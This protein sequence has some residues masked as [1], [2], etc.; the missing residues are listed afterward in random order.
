MGCKWTSKEQ[1]T[2]LH[3]WSDRYRQAGEKKNYNSFWDKLFI[4][5]FVAFPKLAPP[6]QEVIAPE[7]WSKAQKD[8]MQKG[9]LRRKAQLKDWFWNHLHVECH[10]DVTASYVAKLMQD[11]EKG[12]GK[13]CKKL[14][15]VFSTQ[16]YQGSKAQTQE[17][18]RAKSSRHMKL[19]T[20]EITAAWKHTNKEQKEVVEATLHSLRECQELDDEGEALDNG[21]T[22]ENIQRLPL[23]MDAIMRDMQDKTGWCFSVLTEGCG[24]TGH[25]KTA[26]YHLGKM[27]N[28]NTFAKAF[29][30]FNNG[31]MK[32]WTSFV[33]NVC[34]EDP[35][36]L[37][38]SDS[39][40]EANRLAPMLLPPTQ[41]PPVL[42]SGEA[43]PLYQ[44]ENNNNPPAHVGAT[45]PALGEG[46]IC[47]TPPPA[48]L[49][50]DEA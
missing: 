25:V 50:R 37:G 36:L 29:T 34:G 41:L 12:P 18:A 27:K 4:E 16:F 49:N 46:A 10:V 42:F 13:R 47:S 20:T 19:Y 2:L 6:E 22:M 40:S 24:P 39:L 8:E 43:A 48:T 1:E 38:P 17:L 33:R 45:L 21:S 15:E 28:R 35:H 44:F 9:I 3:A 14:A 5:W 7:L 11:V 30:D 26:S 32:P 23:H 31:I